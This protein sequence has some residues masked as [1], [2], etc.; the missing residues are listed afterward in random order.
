MNTLVLMLKLA[1]FNAENA[2]LCINIKTNN[3]EKLFDSLRSLVVLP[4]PDP[5]M[6]VANV[7]NKWLEKWD[8][9]LP[10][11]LLDRNYSSHTLD[12]VGGH[13]AIKTLAQQL[14]N[15]SLR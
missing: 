5:I 6:L 12:V 9:L 7:M 2:G 14:K 3:P 4:P 15:L 11:E 10:D 13:E 1:G 8:T